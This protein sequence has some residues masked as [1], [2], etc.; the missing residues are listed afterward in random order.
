MPVGA[1]SGIGPV[2]V[3][4]LGALGITSIGELQDAPLPLLET[5]VCQE[6]RLAQGAR[7]RRR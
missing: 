6:R 2:T 4:R 1:I 5:L 7:L 3:K